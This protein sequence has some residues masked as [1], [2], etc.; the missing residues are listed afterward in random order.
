VP[1]TPLRYAFEHVLA[2]ALLVIACM[3]FFPLNDPLLWLL[4]FI[5]VAGS[6]AVQHFR[7]RRLRQRQEAV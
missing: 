1:G 2:N 7:V 3:I 5:V 4:L 6:L